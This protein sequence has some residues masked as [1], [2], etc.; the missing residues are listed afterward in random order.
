MD[1]GLTLFNR[2][3]GKDG[4]G[5]SKRFIY[6]VLILYISLANIFC[7]LPYYWPGTILPSKFAMITG[8]CVINKPWHLLMATLFVSLINARSIDN[9]VISV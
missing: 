7:L 9:L 2:L 8:N 1:Q 5:I 3:R 4:N 6:L